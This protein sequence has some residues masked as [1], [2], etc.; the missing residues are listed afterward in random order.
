MIYNSKQKLLHHLSHRAEKVEASA[1]DANL[2]VL[3]K[4]S[5]LHYHERANALCAL[6][7]RKNV[8]SFKTDI[9]N[10]FKD[11]TN[12]DVIIFYAACVL[13]VLEDQTAKAYFFQYTSDVVRS[14]NFFSFYRTNSEYETGV[15]ILA[16]E[17]LGEKI[18]NRNQYWQLRYSD[19]DFYR[20]FIDKK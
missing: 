2:L 11:S 4:D 15:A 12:E 14:E 8:T 19:P 18:N 10:I 3:L 13:A 20:E 9:L 5:S 6:G 7:L 1:T 17:V 16:L